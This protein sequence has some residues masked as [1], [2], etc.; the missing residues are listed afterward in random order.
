MV[1][2]KLFAGKEQR[3]RHREWTC[4]HSRGGM[5]GMN[6]ESSNSMYT[7]SGVRWMAAEKL[8]YSTGSPAPGSVVIQRGEVGGRSG[9]EVQETRDIFIYTADSLYCTTETN[10]TL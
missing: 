7:P 5:E 8:Q 2:M 10:T 6:G 3:L 9:R 1:L 4:G